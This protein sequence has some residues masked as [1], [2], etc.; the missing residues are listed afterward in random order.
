MPLVDLGPMS[1]N[2]SVVDLL[3]EKLSPS[4]AKEFLQCPRKFHFTTI[5]KRTSLPT[6]ATTRG[7]V[8]HTA[9]ER[10]FDHPRQERTVEVALSYVGPAWETM[11]EP[12]KERDEVEE[13]TPEF[14]IRE[15]S[16]LFAE[17]IEPGSVKEDQMMRSAEEYLEVM[18]PGSDAEAQMLRDAH[19]AVSNYFSIER[20]HNF[21]PEDRELYLSAS[22]GSVTVHGFIDRLDRYMT[23]AGEEH[24]V[25]SDYKTGKPPNPRFKDDAF[26]A[27]RVY[28]WLLSQTSG[29]TPSYLR[30][31]FL[32][33]TSKKTGVVSLDV[34]ESILSETQDELERIWRDILR[35][36][37]RDVWEAKTG[38][39]CNWCDFKPECPAFGNSPTT[40]EEV[41]EALSPSEDPESAD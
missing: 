8:A 31:I 23:S 11:I 16:R 25:I 38:P 14:R 13:G 5:L 27:M 40:P 4:R 34:T 7:T 12:L 33:Q 37:E 17:F 1:E 36:A 15:A 3:P 2:R 10:L 19:Q 26:F 9:L 39:L 41:L 20:P 32:T 28:A 21:D 29:V 18:P 30:L 6:V 24:W 22:T 35:A